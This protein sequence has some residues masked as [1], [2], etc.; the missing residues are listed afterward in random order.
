M[1]GADVKNQL[2]W[3]EVPN[4][5]TVTQDLIKM[6]MLLC[7]GVTQLENEVKS[8]H[9]DIKYICDRLG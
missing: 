4:K 7:D 9:A 1:K 3:Y 5:D 2:G 6:I 8:I